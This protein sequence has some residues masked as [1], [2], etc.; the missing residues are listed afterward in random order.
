MIETLVQPSKEECAA[1]EKTFGG[2]N[3]S[4]PN[5][6]E[7][8]S[9]QFAQSCFF[10]YCV[11][12]H[13][14]RQVLEDRI[15]KDKLLSPMEGYLP[16]RIFYTNSPHVRGYAMAHDYYGEKVRYFKFTDCH[17]EWVPQ[18]APFNNYHVNKCSK[19]NKTWEYDTSG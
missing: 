14:T 8:T 4:L 15:N 12:G 2:Y 10:V 13:E 18:P 7:I 11:T 1:H 6:E 16:L 5:L 3:D 19:C 17:H 9:E